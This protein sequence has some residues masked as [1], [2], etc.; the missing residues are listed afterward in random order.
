MKKKISELTPEEKR[1]LCGE[2]CGVIP[3]FEWQV[4]NEDET[5]SC[6]SGEK[7]ECEQ[8]LSRIQKEYPDSDY[9][10][11]HVGAWKRYPRYDESRDAMAAAEATLTDDEHYDFRCE[12]WKIVDSV[13]PDEIGNEWRQERAYQSLTVTQRLDA[14]LIA[15]GLATL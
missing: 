15:K 13:I 3:I 9:S 2:A 10:K 4:M 12:L 6:M 5:A 7:H 1:I 11:Y 14:F 8:W